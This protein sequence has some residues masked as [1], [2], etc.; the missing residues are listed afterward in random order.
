[1]KV[2]KKIVCYF[3][4]HY[5]ASAS[6]V[7]CSAMFLFLARS[8]KRQKDKGWVQKNSIGLV[9]GNKEFFIFYLTLSSGKI[10]C[11]PLDVCLYLFPCR[12]Q[13]GQATWD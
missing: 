11:C 5:N 12:L 10:Y 9:A 4:C 3:L 7:I 1:M 13:F 6:C 8:Q 2:G